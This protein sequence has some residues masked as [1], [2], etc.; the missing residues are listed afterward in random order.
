MA[1]EPNVS[2]GARVALPAFTPTAVPGEALVARTV[3]RDDVVERILASVRTAARTKNRPHALIVGPRGSGK[4]HLLAV[5]MHRLA[6][7]AK[8]LKR[9]AIAWLPEDAVD[10]VSYN[11]L[12]WAVVQ[13][14]LSGGLGA[15]DASASLDEA[16]AMRGRGDIHGL[17]QLVIR[18]LDGRVLL[19]VV[20]NLDRLF[21]D[22]GTEGEARF[23]SFVE[24]SGDVL[25][26]ASTPLLFGGVSDHDRP[27]YGS[28]NAEHLADLDVDDGTELLRRVAE[29]S[30]DAPLEAFLRTPEAHAR[31][32]AV[33]HLAGGSPRMW[34]VLA[35]CMT[36]ELIDELVPLVEEMLDEL[37]P[38]YQARLLELP[39]VERKVV[40]ELCRTTVVT[41]G[42]TVVHE[43]QGMRTVKDLAEACGLDQRVAATALGRLHEAKWVRRAKPEGA[44][45]RTTWYEI[46]E[47][48]LRHH[49]QYRETRGEPL[50][51]I[52][53]FLRSWYSTEEHRR[54][55]AT[56][57]AAS[58][59]E[60]YIREALRDD[61]WMRRSD[62][63]F[64]D[65]SSSDLITAAR[66][67]FG[68]DAKPRTP[69]TTA[70]AIVAEA[71]GL[72]VIES[73]VVRPTVEQ[74]LE[75]L[76]EFERD[77]VRV[78]A[79]A[80]VA[81]ATDAR[82]VTDGVS[83]SFVAAVATGLAA[84]IPTAQ[85]LPIND[86]LSV[87]TVAAGWCARTRNFQHLREALEAA[88]ADKEQLSEED[89]RRLALEYQLALVLAL[90]DEDEQA[91]ELAVS[92]ARRQSEAFGAEHLDTLATREHL[93]FLLGRRGE[94]A[95]A[96]EAYGE[97]IA[98]RRGAGT[99]APARI[100]GLRRHRASALADGDDLAGALDEV[101]RAVRDAEEALG[102]TAGE[103]SACRVLRAR[104]LARAGDDAAAR[105]GAAQLARL[106]GESGDPEQVAELQH[107]AGM[108]FLVTGDYE[109]AS[110]NL[111]DA[112]Q[113]YA[114]LGEQ[115]RVR[116]DQAR[117]SRAICMMHLDLHEE[118]LSLLTDI[119]DA[120][121]E[122]SRDAD[123]RHA[124]Q[125]FNLMLQGPPLSDRLLAGDQSLRA[126]VERQS[127][128]LLMET[129]VLWAAAST[130]AQ[131]DDVADV[132]GWLAARARGRGLLLDLVS[133]CAAWTIVSPTPPSS[134]WVEAVSNAAELEP[135]SFPVGRI[136]RCLAAHRAGDPAALLALPAEERQIAQTLIDSAAGRT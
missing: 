80:G 64:A 28:F 121:G 53:D 117:I 111:A 3:G 58:L 21:S 8:T 105:D 120:V 87:A 102:P 31:L 127:R 27:W 114:R 15:D 34:M 125:L 22:F 88:T 67:S 44:D 19:L 69:M 6:G 37:V 78:A 51:V 100:I 104:I 136:I 86:L 57:P 41:R 89:P 9:L 56:V 112:E 76:P 129:V 49:L 119:L 123:R 106:A 77:A 108:V 85:Q 35:S 33:A 60:R 42:G 52:V 71:V 118:G 97:L 1:P 14:L 110:R 96:A 25:L 40:T 81:A 29:T 109:P 47:P 39:G 83:P 131:D 101:T 30:G 95:K 32:K 2:R 73:K 12:L 75:L 93:A 36:I 10:V 26:L 92:L 70:A 126:V 130:A 98:A 66:M 134:R 17:E 11:D 74:R 63:A 122:A 16:R 4:T 24:T 65:L 62:I 116:R 43:P 55:L 46:R 90:L 94:N 91:Y 23:R 38:Y 115:F 133:G 20:E 45:R 82:D 84:A 107:Q 68:R 99:S 124:G 5:V 7:D 103:T 72:A 54:H 59:A 128:H 50:R 113:A 13:R 79:A 48:L 135:D 132:V 61:P 18:L